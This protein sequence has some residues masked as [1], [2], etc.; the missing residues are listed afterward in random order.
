MGLGSAVGA[1]HRPGCKAWALGD[2]VCGAVHGCNALR[3]R[4]GS[5]AQYVEADPVV[6]VRMPDGWEWADGAALGGSCVGAV[7]LA[8][9]R[10]MGLEWPREGEQEGGRDAEAGGP[11]QGSPPRLDEWRRKV[12]VYGGSTACG[13]M[14]I[15]LLRL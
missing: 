8:L 14:A 7:G 6:L 13:T 12:L 15:Q 5:F 3:P 4:V 10:E 2:R 11:G 9:Y 1:I